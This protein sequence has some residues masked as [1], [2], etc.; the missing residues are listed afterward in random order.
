MANVTKKSTSKK[1]PR[2]AQTP[3][4][5]ENEMIALAMEAAREKIE[6]G[7]ASSQ[8]IVH[9]LQLGTEKARLEREKLEAETTLAAAKAE[10]MKSIQTSEQ[11]AQDALAAFRMYQ[12]T[13]FVPESEARRFVLSDD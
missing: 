13:N 1:S 9:F 11:I 12:G 4:A 10:A 3:Q 7:T 5:Q 6:N 8:I 2:I